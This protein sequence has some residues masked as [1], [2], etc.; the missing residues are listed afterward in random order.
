MRFDKHRVG[1]GHSQT[2]LMMTITRMI[3]TSRPSNPMA[4]LLLLE[5]LT[6]SLPP[7]GDINNNLN[8]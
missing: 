2:I 5:N 6:N 7:H 3:A 1:P 8:S 4:C